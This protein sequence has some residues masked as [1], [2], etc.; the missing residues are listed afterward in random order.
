MDGRKLNRNSNILY[1]LLRDSDFNF[2]FAEKNFFS[3]ENQDKVK[4]YS[5]SSNQ[6][7]NHYPNHYELTRKDLMYKNLRKFKK[8]LIKDGKHHEANE[9]NFFPLTYYMPN[10]YAIFLSVFKQDP[11]QIW[12]MKPA[13]KAQG[14]GIFLI[15]SIEQVTKW[16]NSLT[17]TQ[18][19][20]VN[21]IY[22]IQK[23]LMNPL[24]IGGKKFDMRIYSMVNSY[25]PLT[26]WLYR[27]GFA[28]FTHA[29]YNNSFDQLENQYIHLTNVAVQ[30]TCGDYSGVTGGKWNLRNLK[31]YLY[32]VYPKERVETLFEK[33][34]G[35]IIKSIKSVSKLI[36]NDKHSFELYGFDII[37]N[38]N[39]E[40]ILLEVNANSSLSANT[41]SDNKLKVKMLDDMLSII[42]LEKVMLNDEPQIG[43]FDLIYKGNEIKANDYSLVKSRLGTFNNREDQM[44]K[45]AKA[46]YLKHKKLFDQKQGFKSN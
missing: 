46:T 3:L 12:I 2:Y 32:T 28:R 26:I 5:L 31:L 27:T 24:L 29:R 7:I 21:E 19:N 43:G 34:Q 35:I 25:N 16:K 22:V 18:D 23:Y 40:P 38:D 39:L 11:N 4:A 44:K 15:S 42:D 45:L 17:G 9:Y 14:R 6:K 20:L 1:I 36:V 13:C 30:K 37:I 41:E 8:Q 33:I 10:E